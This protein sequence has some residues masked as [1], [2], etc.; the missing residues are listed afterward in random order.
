[1]QFSAS[2]YDLRYT[3]NSTEF[4]DDSFWEDIRK[5][6]EADLVSGNFDPVESGKNV[7]FEVSRN[8]FNESNIYYL[9]VR[10]YDS[11]NNRS[12]ISDPIELDL[13]SG[14]AATG[15]LIGL[16]FGALMILRRF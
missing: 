13:G 12:P 10:S 15:S 11:V 16:L 3:T 14:A 8:L 5:I 6:S 4:F 7:T 9:S 2:F 1:M